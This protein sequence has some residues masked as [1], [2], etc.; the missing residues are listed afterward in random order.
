MTWS[1]VFDDFDDFDENEEATDDDGEDIDEFGMS[2]FFLL[3]ELG[4]LEH[5]Q[6]GTYPDREA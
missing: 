1:N 4:I 5:A 2:L 3:V 6:E